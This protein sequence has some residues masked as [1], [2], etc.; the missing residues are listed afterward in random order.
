MQTI[1]CPRGQFTLSEETIKF[2]LIST[3]ATYLEFSD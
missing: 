1:A 2:N 3:T